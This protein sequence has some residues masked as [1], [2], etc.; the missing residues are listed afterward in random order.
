[1]AG[2]AC[3]TG[4]G[5]V[6]K[7]AGWTSILVASSYHKNKEAM[8]RAVCA[9]V[10]DALEADGRSA[11][12]CTS[13][14]SGAANRASFVAAMTAATADHDAHATGEHAGC[15]RCEAMRVDGRMCGARSCGARV[16]R[17]EEGSAA[18]AKTRKLPRCAGCGQRAYCC[19]A[20]QRDDWGRH[21]AACKAAQAAAR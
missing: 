17:A 5:A 10:L 4:A 11:A 1:M 3:R 8:G 16:R 15:A 13:A 2:V 21:K 7:L 9:G 6:A 18:A 12:P 19:L 20:H 14:F